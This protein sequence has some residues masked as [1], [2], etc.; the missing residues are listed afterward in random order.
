MVAQICCSGAS[1]R[2][3]RLLW[4]HWDVDSA[5]LTLWAVDSAALTP[6][7]AQICCSAPTGRSIVC[8]AALC[9]T[10][11]PKHRVWLRFARQ[12]FENTRLCCTLLDSNSKAPVLTHSSF[13]RSHC[14]KWLF[15]V[16]AIL[17]LRRQALTH[18][19]FLRSH[20]SKSP[21]FF[22]LTP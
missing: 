21:H 13:L 4:S 2:S 6:L 8:C 22:K 20:C 17:P 7:G 11:R 5:A 19:S 16:T 14:S 9:S 12:H 1:G 15:E 10:T 3:N 18:S